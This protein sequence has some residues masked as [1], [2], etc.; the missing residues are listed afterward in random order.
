MDYTGG[1]KI[2]LRTS[3]NNKVVPAVLKKEK[4]D[5]QHRS[6]MQNLFR[7]QNLL[8][9]LK[10]EMNYFIERPDI[11]LNAFIVINIIC[12]WMQINL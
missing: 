8:V 9:I 2:A 1:I 5:L 6:L 10:K 12:G 4:M 3:F 11:C 7:G